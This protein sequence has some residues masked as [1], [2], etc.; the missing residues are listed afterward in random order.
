MFLMAAKHKGLPQGSSILL[1]I[2]DVIVFELS[3]VT[4]FFLLIF[5]GLEYFSHAS[6]IS[7]GYNLSL[8]FKSLVFKFEKYS[9]LNAKT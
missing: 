4:Q 6:F 2:F 9:K 7:L 5:L 3:N 8:R 1:L